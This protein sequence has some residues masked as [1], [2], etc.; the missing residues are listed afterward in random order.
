MINQSPK[1]QPQ[2]TYINTNLPKH[3][4]NCKAFQQKYKSTNKE[5][6]LME[7]ENIAMKGESEQT[8]NL[9]KYQHSGSG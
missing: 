4:I 3:I 9:K 8:K 7:Y 1:K 6:Y 2:N 5:I